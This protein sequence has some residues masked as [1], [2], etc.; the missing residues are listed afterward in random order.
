MD[1]K[2]YMNKQQAKALK[3]YLILNDMTVSEFAKRLGV[4]QS[5][6]SF[7]INGKK[8]ITTNLI[9]KFRENGFEL[10]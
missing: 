2:N 1:N 9:K 10:W 7:V 6:L 3:I 4:S 8:A 5:F